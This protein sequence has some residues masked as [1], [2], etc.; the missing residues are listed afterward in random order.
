MRCVWF[1]CLECAA[2]L[3][4]AALSSNGAAALAHV[5]GWLVVF[6]ALTSNGA[7]APSHELA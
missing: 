7:A 3:S 5:V 1:K 2:A 4:H 6:A